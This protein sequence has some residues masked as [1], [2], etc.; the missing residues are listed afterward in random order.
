MQM[1]DNI[2]VGVQEIGWGGDGITDW[3]DVAQNCMLLWRSVIGN[4]T[5]TGDA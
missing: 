1:G 2:K 3:F 4:V 5:N